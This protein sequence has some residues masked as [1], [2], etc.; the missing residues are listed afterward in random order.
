MI[1]ILVTMYNEFILCREYQST[2]S[3]TALRSEVQDSN[4]QEFETWIFVHSAPLKEP[5]KLYFKSKMSTPNKPVQKFATWARMQT[6]GSEILLLSGS[7]ILFFYPKSTLQFYSKF[8]QLGLSIT[9]LIVEYFSIDIPVIWQYNFL[10]GL[11]LIAQGGIGMFL[12]PLHPGGI[13]TI[14]AGLTYW[15]ASYNG[16]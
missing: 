7:I 16:E 6:I 10:K 5:Y 8:A 13:C 15:T 11:V 2:L 14:L 3:P 12:A 4:N 1:N 9:L